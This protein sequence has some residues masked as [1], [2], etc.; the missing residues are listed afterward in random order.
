MPQNPQL[1]QFIEGVK[2]EERL[3]LNPLFFASLPLILDTTI[4]FPFFFGEN[5][6]CIKCVVSKKDLKKG[7]LL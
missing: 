7:L 4:F 5:L 3:P 6:S 2:N 1:Y